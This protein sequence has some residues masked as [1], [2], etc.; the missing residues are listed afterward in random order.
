MPHIVVYSPRLP[1]EKKVACVAALTNAFEESTGLDANLLTIH[2]EEH[3][4]DNIG[5]GGKLL[6][7]AYPEIA[8][9]EKQFQETDQ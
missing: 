8:E 2:I 6:T 7:D 1:R 4:Y 5:V 9:R 3:S